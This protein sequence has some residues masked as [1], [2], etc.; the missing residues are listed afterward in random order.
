MKTLI[1]V[2]YVVKL[3]TEHPIQVRQVLDSIFCL[4]ELG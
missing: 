4:L 2:T 1:Y 3:S